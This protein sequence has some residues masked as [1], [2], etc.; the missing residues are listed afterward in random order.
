MTLEEIEKRNY[1]N[2][3]IQMALNGSQ[4]VNRQAQEID[5]LISEVKRLREENERLRKDYEELI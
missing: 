4:K 1:Y 5:W 3:K 2:K